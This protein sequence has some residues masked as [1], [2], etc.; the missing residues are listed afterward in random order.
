MSRKA[1]N[2]QKGTIEQISYSS[3]P[4]TIR[5]RWDSGRT[6]IHKG[7]GLRLAP[8]V[9]SPANAAPPQ[10][11]QLEVTPDAM[12][13]IDEDVYH[14]AGGEEN[15]IDEENDEDVRYDELGEGAM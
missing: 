2:P 11:A 13:A 9:P 10:A 7:Q 1:R 5:V 8:N 14:A 3:K 15:F 12:D 6:S 4:L